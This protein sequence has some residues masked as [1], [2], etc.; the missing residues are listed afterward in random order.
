[1]IEASA[2]VIQTAKSQFDLFFSNIRHE[3]RWG[4]YG[5]EDCCRKWLHRVAPKA[6]T[7]Q[8]VAGLAP[9]YWG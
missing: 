3:A 7:S 1:M 6:R 9:G 2:C 8:P 4:S 5:P